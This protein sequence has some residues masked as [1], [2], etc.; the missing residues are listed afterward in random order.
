[1]TPIDQDFA[2]AVDNWNLLSSGPEGFGFLFDLF[3]ILKDV[4]NSVNKLLGLV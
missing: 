3:E 1:M 4:A 2:T